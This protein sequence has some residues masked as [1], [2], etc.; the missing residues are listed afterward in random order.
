MLSYKRSATVTFYILCGC[1]AVFAALIVG[2]PFIMPFLEKLGHGTET[3]Y[4]VFLMAFYL[5]SVPA[6]AVIISL[7]KLLGNIRGDRLFIKQNVK[8]LN[9]ISYSCFAVVP[10]CFAA[11]FW[12][13]TLFA[14]SAAALFF[15][16]TV[17]I[18]MHAFEYA[19]EIKEENELTV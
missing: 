2:A 4:A 7:F 19:A 14:V 11:G 17:R 13:I 12:F 16:F 18:I 10:I 3:E 1:T 8:L 6:T 9:I 15:G 5:C